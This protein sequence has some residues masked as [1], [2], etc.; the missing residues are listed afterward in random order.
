MESESSN[1]QQLDGLDIT[2][3]KWAAEKARGEW[4]RA[5][6]RQAERERK[7]AKPAVP[8]PEEKDQQHGNDA[9][10]DAQDGRL[11]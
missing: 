8:Q 1:K 7:K 4:A 5:A 9:P 10:E 2:R 11:H 3:R 6:Q